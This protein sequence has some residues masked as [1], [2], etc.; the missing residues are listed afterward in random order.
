MAVKTERQNAEKQNFQISVDN[1]TAQIPFQT[2]IPE[3]KG[4]K[5]AYSV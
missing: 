4:T 2:T 1:L 3:P 5:Q